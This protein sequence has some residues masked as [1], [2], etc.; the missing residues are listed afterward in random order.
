MKTPFVTEGRFLLKP[1]IVCVS[2]VAIVQYVET[3]PVSPI[4]E[5]AT[6]GI[7]IPAAVSAFAIA[8]GNGNYY[9]RNIAISFL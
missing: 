6:V 7:I 2:E 3:I 8:V 1:S 4:S 5:A 9:R